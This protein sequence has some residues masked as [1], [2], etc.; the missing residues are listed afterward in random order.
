MGS[1]FFFLFFKSLSFSVVKPT[2]RFY[3]SPYKLLNIGN[4]FLSNVGRQQ[5][6]EVPRVREFNIAEDGSGSL[7][8]DNGAKLQFHHNFLHPAYLHDNNTIYYRN[9]SEMFIQGRRS[10]RRKCEHSLPY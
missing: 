9:E 3:L 5:E 2:T 6:P 1:I 8:Y 4:V 10:I 7:L